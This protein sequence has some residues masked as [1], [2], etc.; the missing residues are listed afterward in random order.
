MTCPY[1]EPTATSEG[2]DCTELGYRCFRCRA[3][4]QKSN[5]RTTTPFNRLQYPA[6]EVCLVILW[7]F[8]YKLSL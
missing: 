2:P 7:C 6:D 5:E 3:C 4:N 1:Y 8:R